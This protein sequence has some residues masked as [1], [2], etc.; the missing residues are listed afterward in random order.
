M[1]W[2]MVLLVAGW[3]WTALAAEPDARPVE[4]ERQERI[5]K[6]RRMQAEAGWHLQLG[7]ID[8]AAL[9]QGEQLKLL[10]QLYSKDS[11][12]DGQ[13]DLASSLNNMGYLLHL[14]GRW[15]SSLEHYREA[16][17]MCRRLYP[18]DK[19]PEGHPHLAANLA[20]M[21][22]VLQSLGRLDE[23]LDHY[24]QALAMRRRLYPRDKFPEGH[25]EIATS[26]N[27]MGHGLRP[28]GRL[29]EALDHHQQALAM[30]RQLYPKDR[31]PE[32]HPD[33]AISLG[34][35]GNT[36]QLL[37]RLEAALDY[38]QQAVAMLRLLFPRDRFP[39]GNPYLATGL[40][41]LGYGLRSLGRLEA[42]LDHHQQALAMFQQL[43]PPDRF[44]Q[45]HPDL[46]MTLNNVGYILEQ[47][48]RLEAALDHHQQAAE[49][50]RRLYTPERFPVGHPDLAMSLN[51]LG[52]MA[53]LLGQP[54]QALTHW[55]QALAMLRQ[56]YPRERF[57]AGHPDLATGLNNMGT[58]LGLVGRLEE[59]LDYHQQTLEMLHRLYPRDR[60]PRGHPDLAMNPTTIA[61]D[62]LALGRTKEALDHNQQA[63]AM[64]RRLYPRD[65]F[66]EG[67]PDLAYGL[68]RQGG[69]LHLVGQ[70]DPAR[71]HL[72]EA[73]PMYQALLREGSA[74]ASEGRILALIRALP[75]CRDNH[76]SI[77]RNQEGFDSEAYQQV[78][79]SRA[80]VTRILQ[81][82]Q[83]ALRQ[84]KQGSP[85][86]DRARELQMVRDRI[87]Q[88]I[89]QAGP[90][91]PNRDTLLAT[92][93]RRREQLEGELARLLPL[94][95]D[96]EL[97]PAR[98]LERLPRH[99][100]FLDLVRYHLFQAD[101]SNPERPVFRIEP[102]YVAFVLSAGQSVRRVE[103]GEAE[104]IDQA[105]AAFRKDILERGDSQAAGVLGQK[106]WQPLARM[107]PADTRTLFLAVDGDLAR[108]PFAA[109]P[110]IRP[111]SSLL[112]EDCA[113]VHIPHGQFLLERLLRPWKP[114][115]DQDG[116]LLLG[117]LDYG[118]PEESRAAG[119][120]A[121]S[122]LPA[123]GE[124]IEAIRRFSR[125]RSVVA[126]E[127]AS[128][129]VQ[130]VC[131]ELPRA[132]F[133][134]L[135][136]HGYFDEKGL[137]AEKQALAQLLRQGPLDLDRPLPAVGRG[138]LSPL[139]YTGLVLSGANRKATPGNGI[140]TGENLWS[141]PLEGLELAVLSSCETGL[142]EL[143]E[144]EAVVGL[145]RTLHLAG[146]R[147]VVASLWKIPDGSTAVLMEE[148]YRRLWDPKEP[149][150]AAEAL[151]QAQLWVYR[152]PDQVLTRIKE[153]RTR[154]IDLDLAE[155][156][157]QG[158]IEKRRFSPARW[159]AGF[160][161]SGDGSLIQP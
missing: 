11:F 49:M 36:L 18:R 60:F 91:R 40:N 128:A 27:N 123:T 54:D 37:G 48:G 42:A 63:L 96:Q 135:A 100:A 154:G 119:R 134:H 22:G 138:S 66:P 1:R 52:K 8:Q 21:G 114:V 86:A 72:L 160:I 143:T 105:V 71:R 53:Q 126:L 78:W 98:L 47:L 155:L 25:P 88:L 99:T 113:V 82:R 131:E 121:F 70:P 83:L 108:L 26:L 161:L 58:A 6:A 75:R 129:T 92:L 90:D 84:Q 76:L 104:P 148:F 103:L 14:L 157:N 43:Y 151:R 65:R 158:T 110:G 101:H 147:D 51:H 133:A 130:R 107:L 152:H 146:C 44:P 153:M 67:H 106:L 144:G 41:N 124:E 149:L 55:T 141:L 116:L 12:P 35:M 57:P 68:I 132:R 50:R 56:L 81:Q 20:N 46:A 33:L 150:P 34:N 93:T 120:P 109:L 94:P 62:L 125:S 80:F 97:A 137:K 13:A 73:A 23:A 2:S 102:H 85:V 117:N 16:A 59:A 122:A 136:V 28:L 3:G 142:G 156:P 19:F 127:K 140:L 4:K 39:L 45:G 15:E 74:F 115:P 38:H 159:W 9:V 118:P 24:R 145:Q 17:A 64:L 61:H 139:A 69:M 7:R 95:S 89:V 32:G 77:T 29:E 31:F 111:G 5:E 79:L 112:L 30:R 10:R 87:A